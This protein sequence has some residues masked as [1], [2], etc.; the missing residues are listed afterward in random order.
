MSSVDSFTWAVHE[1]VNFFGSEGAAAESET[2]KMGAS[3]QHPRGETQDAGDPLTVDAVRRLRDAG[4]R[5][6]CEGSEAALS[7]SVGSGVFI[8]GEDPLATLQ[9]CD[10]VATP[11]ETQRTE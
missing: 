2:E 9:S 8:P 6:R 10:V 3:D 1:H 5:K 4:I 7:I 11:R